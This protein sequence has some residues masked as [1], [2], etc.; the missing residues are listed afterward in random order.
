MTD[1]H[2]AAGRRLLVAAPV[3]AL[4]LAGLTACGGPA[5]APSPAASSASVNAADAAAS[6][7]RDKALAA[8]KAVTSYAFNSTEVLG[9][10]TTLITGRVVLPTSLDYVVSKGSSQ[11]EVV[12][13]NG[14]TYVRDMPG[15]FK[16]LA[17]PGKDPSPLAGLLAALQGAANLTVDS[18]GTH[19][20]GSMTVAQA[21]AAGLISQASSSTAMIPVT[22]T[23]DSTGRVT[24]FGLSATLSIGGKQVTLT[25]DTTYSAFGKVPPVKAP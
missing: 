13:V 25:E 16:K 23:L 6:A 4:L 5:S 1:L 11:Q 12:R 15:T 8:M 18:S 17:N 2:K 7:A 22:F 10:D 20:T 21:T 24:E 19:L 3:A 14:A 9:S